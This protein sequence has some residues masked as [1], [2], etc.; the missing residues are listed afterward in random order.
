MTFR[1]LHMLALFW[2]MGGVGAVIVPIWRAWRVDDLDTRAIM[3]T[4]AQES[5]ARWLLPGVIATWIT[6][7]AWASVDDW[8]LVTTGWL[9]AL[10]LIFFVVTFI[11]LPLM[12]VGLRRVRLLTLQARK[13]G[14]MTPE[15]QEALH[16][17]VPLVFGTL[18]V[19]AIP[20]MVWLPVFQPF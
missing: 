15:L 12:G 17:N 11:F 10:E 4:Q 16:D 18:I 5:E 6:G 20:L 19:A 9:L 3:L 13:Q 2:M 14:K 8:N 7:I 1:L